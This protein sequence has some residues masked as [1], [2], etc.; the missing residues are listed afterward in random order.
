[1]FGVSGA[2]CEGV[3]P[4]LTINTE[5]DAEFRGKFEFDYTNVHFS[6]TLGLFL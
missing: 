3:L 1:M 2:L 4:H 5:W 6:K